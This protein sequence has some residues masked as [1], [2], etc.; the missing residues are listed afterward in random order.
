MNRE[1]PGSRM[2]GWPIVTM[3]LVVLAGCSGPAPDDPNDDQAPAIDPRQSFD[4]STKLVF[5]F[6]PAPASGLA[7]LDVVPEDYSTAT[8]DV[9]G[10]QD[11]LLQVRVN[12]TEGDAW[13]VVLAY[14]VLA[15]GDLVL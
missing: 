11:L 12:G 8:G 6:A 4:L 5:A 15:S 14:E 2:R 3:T 7:L 1:G 10:G 9:L 13:S